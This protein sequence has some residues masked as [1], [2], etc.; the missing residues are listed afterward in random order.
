LSYKIKKWEKEILLYRLNGQQALSPSH[1]LASY[2][3]ELTNSVESK[4]SSRPTKKKIKQF[5]RIQL[6]LSSYNKSM[7]HC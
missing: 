5:N 3:D 2:V 1:F 6:T 4:I 7:T